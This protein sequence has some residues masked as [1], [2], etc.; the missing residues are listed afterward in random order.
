MRDEDRPARTP[1]TT[2]TLLAR[3][4]RVGRSAGALCQ[5]LHRHEGEAGVRR[6]LGV[7]ALAKKHGAA[8]TEAACEAALALG[9]PS[10]GFVK[11]YLARRLMT[12]PALTQ[13]DPL[14][15]QLTLYR[16]EIDRL[17]QPKEG[18]RP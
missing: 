6:I 11:R 18:D 2:L 15:R 9:A 12:A 7:L 8:S 13:I 14:I 3:A 16:E 1:A 5:Q 17:T 4:E 10:Y